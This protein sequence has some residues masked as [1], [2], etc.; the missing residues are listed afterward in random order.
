MIAISLRLLVASCLLLSL[1]VSASAQSNTPAVL[2]DYDEDAENYSKLW[3]ETI[4]AQTIGYTAI[5]E[6]A[7]KL[8]KSGSDAQR[9][10]ALKE[11]GAAA[12][13]QPNN[14]EAHFWKGHYLADASQWA[15]CA[16]ELRIVFAIDPH[17]TSTRK[18]SMDLNFDLARCNLYSDNYEE[19]ITGFK[20][21]LS[22]SPGT[23]QVELLLGESLMALGKLDQAISILRQT[24]N[25]S[26][27][28]NT[29][30]IL[31]IALD[32]GEYIS[33]SRS[34][35]R[36]I[37]SRD[38]Q[39]RG[40]L[41]SDKRYAPKEDEDYY[42]GLAYAEKRKPSQ[43]LYHFRSFLK[44]APTSPW[45]KRAKQHIASLEQFP[46]GQNG[47]FRGSKNWER[48][49][50][51]RSLQ[52]QSDKLHACIA[53]YPLLLA[54]VQLSFLSTGKKMEVKPVAAVLQSQDVSKEEKATA[55]QCLESAARQMRLPKPKAPK[56]TSARLEFWLLSNP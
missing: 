4:A 13:A 35:L 5:I 9:K 14:P 54:H 46:V 34:R 26:S 28:R 16:T 49:P 55:V 47:V 31:A 19:A 11:L 50:I 18:L 30:Y 8:W 21:I 22:S 40:L 45:S 12:R 39:L 42:L 41:S 23:V 25:H 10:L 6:H 2:K 32:R 38:S 20:R 3:E 1:N 29:E 33:E 7:K 15:D 27:S 43:A 56:G 36:K 51:V 52:G 44:H 53:S 37:L 48:T 17:F 24:A